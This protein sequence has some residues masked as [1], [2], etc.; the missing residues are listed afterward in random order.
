VWRID[1]AAVM[2][3]L[4][5]AV[6][7]TSHIDFGALGAKKHLLLGWGPPDLLPEDQVA[8]VG[9]EGFE[10]CRAERTRPHGNA[11]KTILDKFGLRTAHIANVAVGQLMIRVERACDVRLTFTFGRPSYVRF[12]INGFATTMQP[13]RTATFTVPA[14]NVTPGINIVELAS[15]LPLGYPVHLATLDIAP[16]CP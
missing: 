8:A 15:Q 2:A 5:E 13:G 9:L 12:A 3:L 6:P 14:A 4:G 11:C 10:R 7:V 16:S 1:R